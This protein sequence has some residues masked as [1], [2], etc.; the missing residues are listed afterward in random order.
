MPDETTNIQVKLENHEQRLV[1]A[2][3]RLKDLETDSKVI[4]QLSNSVQ[5][6][7]INMEQM[8]AEQKEQGTRLKVLEDAPLE[9]WNNAK[10]T[11]FTSIVSTIAGALASSLIWLL[12]HG[13]V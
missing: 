5:K 3:H 6:L 7:A 13:G 10:R 1:N 9:T 8:L 4:M 2:E 12:V 11:A